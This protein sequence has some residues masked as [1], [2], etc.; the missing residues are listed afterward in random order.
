MEHIEYSWKAAD[1]QLLYG[2]GWLA[3]GDPKAVVCLVH[4][5]GEHSGRYTWLAGELN[6]AGYSVLSFD[7]RGH[8]KT[9]G[10]RGHC[11]SYDL[12]MDDIAHLIEEA[13]TRFPGKP[14]FLYGHSLGGSL[15]LNFALRRRPQITGVISTSPGL[16][17]G[18]K[19][20]GWQIAM[21][22]VLNVIAPATT[23]ENGLELAN[24]SHDQ[25]VI[26]AYKA[27]PLVH[28]KISVRSAMDLLESGQWALAHAGEFSLPLLIQQGSADKLVSPAAT[29]AFVEKVKG[30]ITYK[31]WP[32]L[33]HETHN[34]FEK[35]EVVAVTIKWLNAH[36]PVA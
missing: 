5:L 1:G 36:T 11:P 15:V 30:D 4:G 24:L 9:L 28:S 34:E 23:I 6:A 27:D 19:L 16:E 22:K 25:A 20:P 8:G 21:S 18:S 33:F 12:G 32:G 29:R 7:L 35:K 13:K 2:Q 26:D 14:V 31:E 3:D 10:I 17:T